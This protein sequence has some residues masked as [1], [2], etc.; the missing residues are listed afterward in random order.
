MTNVPYVLLSR[1]AAL[2]Q[3]LDNIANNIANA[4]TAGFRRDAAIFTEYVNAIKGE[5]SIS[6]TRIGARLLDSAQG[7]MIASGGKLDLAVEGDG[8]FGVITPAGLRLTRA[9]AF[10]L[11]D[12]GVIVTKN[13]FP[14]SGDGGSPINIPPDASEISI[15]ADGSVAADGNI[16]GRIIL[17]AAPNTALAREGNDL[18]LSTEEPVPLDSGRVRQGYLEASNVNPVIE[19]SRLIEVQR[20]FELE[21]QIMNDDARRVQQAIEVLGGAVR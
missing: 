7:E 4:N 17:L 6:Q 16:V 1:Q 3:E 13:G 20:A 18:L 11:N 15:S 10:L 14:V 12:D 21:Q 19:I 9:G 2:A 8:F 5:P